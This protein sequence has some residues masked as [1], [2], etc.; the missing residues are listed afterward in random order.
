MAQQAIDMYVQRDDWDKV[1]Q[2]VERLGFQLV[3]GLHFCHQA[4]L[5]AKL[6]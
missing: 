2:P 4:C 6:G 1:R 5:G 3:L